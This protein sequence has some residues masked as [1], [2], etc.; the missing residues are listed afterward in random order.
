MNT[1]QRV[2]HGYSESVD[3]LVEWLQELIGSAIDD[4]VEVITHIV[5]FQIVKDEHDCYVAIVVV[6]TEILAP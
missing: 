6:D 1:N 3:C 5:H 4:S 2:L